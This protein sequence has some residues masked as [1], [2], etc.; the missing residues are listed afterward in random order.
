[1][2]PYRLPTDVLPTHYDLTLRTDLEKEAFEGVV[3]ID[4]DIV[5]ATDQISLNAFPGLELGPATLS[6]PSAPVSIQP[7]QTSFNERDQCVTYGF[8]QPLEAESKATLNIN[9]TGA[10]TDGMMGYYKS[11]WPQ[12]IYAL[13]QFEPTG[14]RRALPCWDEPMF[15]AR[16]TVTMISRAGL[17]V[18]SNMGTTTEVISAEPSTEPLFQGVSD[19][20]WVATK[21]QTTPPMSTYLL[22]FANGDFAYLE[23]SYTS[24][25]S[26]K[27]CPLPTPDEVNKA[28]FCLDVTVR[29]VPLYEEIFDIEYPLPKLDMLV[30][31]DFDAGAMENWG[32]ITGRA[33]SFLLDPG[34]L[35]LR[36]QKLIAG[37]QCHEVAHMWFG[38]ITT[39]AWWDNLYLNEGF[40]TVVGESIILNKLFP[41]WRVDSEFINEFLNEAL[42][43]DAKLSSHPIEVTVPDANALTQIFDSL[44]Y[45]KAAS[46]LRMLAA[47]VGEHKFLKGVSVYLKKRL[48]AS[49]VSRDL[50]EG[51]GEVTGLDIP[52]I[53][54]PWVSKMGFPV[55][56]VTETESGIRVRQD[57]FLEDGPARPTD[58][59]TIW[60]IP[61][62]LV[63]AVGPVHSDA[64]LDVRE[65]EF[66]LDTTKPFKLNA[67]TN[68]FCRVLYT[69]ERLAA[70]VSEVVKPNSVFSLND[71][72]G[73]VYDTMA[74]AKAGF[75]KLSTALDVVDKFRQEKEYLVWSG[76]AEN[77]A[78]VIRT[79]WENPK[80]H[81]GLNAFRRDVFR[82]IVKRL[83][84]DYSDAEDTGTI[85]LRTTA[86]TQAAN[87]GDVEVIEEL[88]A[89]FARYVEKGEDAA[90]PA[91]LLSI[92]FKTAVAYGGRK[93]YDAVLKIFE[94]GGRNP[95]EHM[96]AIRALG[97]PKDKALL[98]ETTDVILTKARNQDIVGFFKGLSSNVEARRML[99][100]YFEQNYDALRERLSGS[101]MMEYLIPLTYK[102]FASLRDCERVEAFF[103]GKD[104]SKYEMKLA[105]TID[106]IKAKA[107]WIERSTEDVEGW[108]D[109]LA[110]HP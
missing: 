16:F 88:Q 78:M 92:T 5:K 43:L 21:F 104:T 48:Y 68:S 106:S 13:T 24:P 8:A 99:P 3:K 45:A 52:K 74:F 2:H 18:L 98:E 51:I 83:G 6:L 67:G 34:S 65:K 10:L 31:S 25:L 60:T 9:F 79:W 4:L 57:R 26:G 73:I 20:S 110:R 94:S 82:P 77:V 30:A 36:A 108:L 97:A 70:I 93:E 23:S 59:E 56:T 76:I 41:E 55:V 91:D 29:C 95:S 62:G 14:A 109:T 80:V 46:V 50:W 86:I 66:D 85:Q 105:Q 35:D 39:M 44:T 28:Q 47:Y 42:A 103:Q 17:V 101:F 11:T 87:W 72:I 49:S 75:I 84:Y 89:R 58:N 81:D 64:V 54:D 27:V 12:G 22:A 7:A 53:M 33:S 19:G 96:A 107:T 37:M 38:N 15:K 69:P 1:M 90:I 40:A 71:R 102:N 100:N 32:L 63:S 61:L